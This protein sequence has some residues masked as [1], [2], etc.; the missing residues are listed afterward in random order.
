MCTQPC[1]LRILCS[2]KRQLGPQKSDLRHLQLRNPMSIPSPRRPYAPSSY[3]RPPPPFVA[4]FR[5]D[6]S[7]VSSN[8]KGPKIISRRRPLLSKA[9]KKDKPQKDKAQ[10]DKPQKDKPQKKNT[11]KTPQKDHSSGHSAKTETANHPR[12]RPNLPPFGFLR[13]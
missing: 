5:S 11:K 7:A 10:K 1:S 12:Q 3:G 13:K 6:A 2:S 4:P 8:L 9:Y